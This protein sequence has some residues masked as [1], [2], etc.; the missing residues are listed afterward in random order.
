M[1]TRADGLGHCVQMIW[2]IRA[3]HTLDVRLVLQTVSNVLFSQIGH[4]QSP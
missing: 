4:L 3:A 2:N 1:S